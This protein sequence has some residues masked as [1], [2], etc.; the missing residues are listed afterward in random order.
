MKIFTK[1]L[2]TG[3]FVIA[4]DN[5]V[6][7]LSFKTSATD[8]GCTMIGTGNYGNEPSSA[9]TFGA[10]DGLTLNAQNPTS[11]LDGITITHTGGTV[12]IIIGVT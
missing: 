9:M 7:L 12:N 10:G 3:T 1:S 11:P 6:L 8:G 4:S 5:N 2:T